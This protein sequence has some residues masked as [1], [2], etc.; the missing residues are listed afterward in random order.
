MSLSQDCDNPRGQVLVVR[1]LQARYRCCVK[2]SPLLRLKSGLLGWLLLLFA[3]ETVGHRLDE[4]LQAARVSVATNRVDLSLD[5]TPGVSM[6]EQLL[7]VIDKDRDGR[8]SQAEVSAYAQQVLKDIQVGL[9][10][11]VM[12]PRVME[13]S[14]PKLSE[15]KSGHGVIRIK[16]TAAVDPLASGHHA[17]SLTNAH[18]P[19]MSVYLVNALVP[20]DP[21][22]QLGKQ[23]RDDLQKSYHLEFSVRPL[24]R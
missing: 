6:V 13:T 18:L 24:L 17:L 16:A 1:T 23:T 19:S 4:Y 7:V 2:T 3:T 15:I 8:L 20:K 21:A 10:G 14:F 11:K 12:I 5:L 22:I 9:D